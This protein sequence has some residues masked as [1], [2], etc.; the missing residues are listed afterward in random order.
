MIEK[1]IKKTIEI[2]VLDFIDQVNTE[3]FM[4]TNDN[5]KEENPISEFELL[6]HK[7]LYIIYGNFYARFEKELFQRANFEA[8][9]YGPVEIDFRRYFD[10]NKNLSGQEKIKIFSKFNVKLTE[11]E[12]DFLFK[13]VKK[14]LRF[15]P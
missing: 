3:L 4:P 2:N 10:K 15:S 5:E 9:K 12:K 14:T 7:I 1:V 11:E 6:I 8:W 13:I